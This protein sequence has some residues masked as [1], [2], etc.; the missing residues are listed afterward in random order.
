MAI[1]NSFLYVY[2]RVT[3]SNQRKYTQ[4]DFFEVL[5][6]QPAQ[7]AQPAQPLRVWGERGAGVWAE[8]WGLVMDSYGDH[9]RNLT[10]I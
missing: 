10:V 7:P 9:N 3:I 1:F 5:R 8:I 2:R 4:L 6:Q